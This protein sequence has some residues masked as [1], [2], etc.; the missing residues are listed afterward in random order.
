MM[1][2]AR[3]QK[4]FSIFSSSSLQFESNFIQENHREK[5]K[6][7]FVIPKACMDQ[8]YLFFN[9]FQWMCAFGQRQK[10]PIAWI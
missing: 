5:M 6:K 7:H 4:N 2:K 10:V 1:I 8:P 9:V 3:N